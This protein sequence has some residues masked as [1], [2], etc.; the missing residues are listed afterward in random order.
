VGI[1]KEGTPRRVA[2]DRESAE[3][4]VSP[5]EGVL[6]PLNHGVLGLNVPFPFP[7]IFPMLILR[8]MVDEPPPPVLMEGAS[9]GAEFWFRF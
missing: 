4:G 9:G 8:G 1:V 6:R 7:G 5:P 3:P 2:V